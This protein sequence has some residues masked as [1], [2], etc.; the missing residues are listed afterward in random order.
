MRGVRPPGQGAVDSAQAVVPVRREG[1]A[2]RQTLDEL[3]EGEGQQRQGLSAAG[4]G[5]QAAT[6]SGSI[7][8]PAICAGPSMARR[9]M[10]LSN[11]PNT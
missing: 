4:V 1:F 7:R 11:G 2:T 5:D 8:S 9:S 10:S 6:S 3:L